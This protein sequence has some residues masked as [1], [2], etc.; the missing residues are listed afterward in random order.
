[1]CRASSP[2]RR[3]CA[4]AGLAKSRHFA[5]PPWTWSVPYLK[6]SCFE[7]ARCNAR[8]M[9]TTMVPLAVL[10][11]S[12]T[13]GLT[14]SADGW[15][16]A[17]IDGQ[18]YS[19]GATL[20]PG[21]SF[22][23]P[24]SGEGGGASFGN[25][26]G[27]PGHQTKAF[28][29]TSGYLNIRF[30]L[31]KPLNHSEP[32]YFSFTRTGPANLGCTLSVDQTSAELQLG[33]RKIERTYSLTRRREPDYSGQSSNVFSQKR[34]L[35]VSH[36][37]WEQVGNMLERTIVID[38]GGSST[39]RLLGPESQPAPPPGPGGL[40]IGG[41]LDD[42]VGSSSAIVKIFAAGVSDE[43]SG[44]RGVRGTTH[45]FLDA[46]TAAIQGPSGFFDSWGADLSAG[47]FDVPLTS[48]VPGTYTLRLRSGS[49]LTKAI[50]FTAGAT[51][52]VTGLNGMLKFGDF[53]GNGEIEAAELTALQS[54]IGMSEADGDLWYSSI[55][56]FDEVFVVDLDVNRDGV[57]SAADVALVQ[58]YVGHTS[59]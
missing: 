29:K 46:L 23:S 58:P 28:H 33:I 22:W 5:P 39:I 43:A 32:V 59:D 42:A 26:I 19:S 10:A 53:N 18:G 8:K 21:W 24:S 57:L 13:S 55:S 49:S 11:L 41:G 17:K 3:E 40:P 50:T 25:S 4:T 45:G 44:Y 7:E 51:G 6:N 47:T 15:Q 56:G 30:K 27:L 2:T 54:R 20:P 9:L 12:G 36:D 1:M 38:A 31:R 52:H 16:Y 14:V 34:T 48:T 35:A 37:N